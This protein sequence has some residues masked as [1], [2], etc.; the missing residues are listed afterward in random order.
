MPRQTIFNVK[1]R[2][3]VVD[4]VFVEFTLMDGRLVTIMV[5][6]SAEADRL[7]G[8]VVHGIETEYD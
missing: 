7:A 6:N 2:G 3:Q 8:V 5:D 4:E 1:R